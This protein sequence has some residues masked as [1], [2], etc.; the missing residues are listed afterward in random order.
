MQKSLYEPEARSEVEQQVGAVR[1]VLH[2]FR[3]ALEVLAKLVEKRSM[4]KQQQLY[5]ATAHLERSLVEGEKEFKGTHER[6]FKLHGP[7]YTQS[8][9]DS[10]KWPLESSHS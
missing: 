3:T 1:S 8:F 7:Q 4:L 9:T 10:R 6:H 2:A 5:P